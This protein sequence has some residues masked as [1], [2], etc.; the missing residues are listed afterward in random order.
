M[1]GETTDERRGRRRAAPPQA[2]W[3]RPAGGI[4]VGVAVVLL[5][6]G[7]A[8]VE[9]W[10]GDQL[11]PSLRGEAP[12]TLGTRSWMWLHLA[13]LGLLGAVLSLAVPAARRSPWIPTVV[14]ALLLYNLAQSL[15]NPVGHLVPAL[16]PWQPRME[17]AVGAQTTP[18]NP[19]V[20]AI[21]TG[22]SLAAAIWGWRARPGDRRSP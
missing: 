13:W 10:L 8:H 18:W 15:A 22:V 16:G 7:F 17:V 6:W 9:Q 14:A 4:A 19:A 3:A 2:W 12:A 20:I 5:L 11:V 21:A 1:A